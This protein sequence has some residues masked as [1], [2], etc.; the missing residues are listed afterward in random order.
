[1]L[2]HLFTQ[3]IE[4]PKTKSLFDSML[5]MFLQLLTYTGGDVSEALNWMNQ[6]DRQY[7]FSNDE[8]GMGDFIKD[9][10]DKG[11]INQ[12][13]QDPGQFVVNS[14]AGQTIRR[15]S[16]EE[17]FG[18]IK[19]SGRGNHSSPKSGIGDETTADRRPFDFGDEL[20]NIDLTATIHNAQIN[21]GIDEFSLTEEDLIMEEKEHKSL[22]S[23]VL[24]IDISHS[25][26]LYGED[27]IT[28][29]KKT[30]MALAEL[31]KTKYP[32]DNLDIIVFG[33]DAWPVE[34][35][36]L[37]YLQVGPY[38]TNTYAGLDLAI[39][40]L[41]KRKT[42]NKQIFMI[43]DGKPSC[44]RETGGYYK[45][46]FGLDRK[47]VNKTL[48]QAARCRKLGIPITTFMIARDPYLQQF[49]GDFTR[50]NHGRAFYSSLKGL[51]EYIFEDYV[52]NRRRRVR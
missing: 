27:R 39:E 3:Y 38:H 30:A 19:K 42:R 5:D 51:G 10:E 52:R 29:A 40:L 9:L 45:N 18:K 12:D 7:K 6:L 49:V 1:M 4:L 35:H 20:E 46:S 33:N 16:L 25:M 47:I 23:T 13:P 22:N 26:I 17:I 2:G 37:P 32:K 31:I 36:E 41:S 43:T 15:R 21:H 8:Y 34:L 14:K 50:I 48:N 24:M 44:L 11:Y 28:P